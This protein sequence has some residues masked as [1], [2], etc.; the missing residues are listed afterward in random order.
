SMQS[1]RTQSIKRRK[2]ASLG[3]SPVNRRCRSCIS[4]CSASRIAF[5]VSFIVPFDCPHTFHNS[6]V[7][8][9]IAASRL[10]RKYSYQPLMTLHTIRSLW[11]VDKHSQRKIESFCDVSLN[12][13]FANQCRRCV[14]DHRAACSVRNRIER[15]P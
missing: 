5:A 15:Q 4:F 13:S 2:S 9:L 1:S 12:L 10:V 11:K 8:E 3:V 7:G 6:P 14:A